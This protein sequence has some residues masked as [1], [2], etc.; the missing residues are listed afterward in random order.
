MMFTERKAINNFMVSLPSLSSWSGELDA[1]FFQAA[2]RRE[3]SETKEQFSVWLCSLSSPRITGEDL[4]GT[5]ET[6]HGGK[7]RLY[8]VY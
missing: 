1:P 2:E 7:V 8:G 3:S 6:S 4:G 5:R